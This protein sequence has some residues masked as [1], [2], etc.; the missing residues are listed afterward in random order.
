MDSALID[1]FLDDLQLIE[2]AQLQRMRQ[3]WEAGD[4]LE[5]QEAWRVGQDALRSAGRAG[6]LDRTRSVVSDWANDSAWTL[7]SLYGGAGREQTRVSARL[8]A[9]PAILDA[10]LA[11]LAGDALDQDQRYALT[12]PWRAGISGEWSRPRRRAGGT[13]RSSP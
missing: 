5:R 1:Q 10:A 11:I 9:L 8:A 4:T 7:N 3:A 2:P 6:A 13:G 12:K